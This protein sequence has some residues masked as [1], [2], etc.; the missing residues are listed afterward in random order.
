[1]TKA[2]DFIPSDDEH[3]KKPM[4]VIAS[5]KAGN[6]VA[7]PLAKSHI[8]KLED[9]TGVLYNYTGQV[10]SSRGELVRKLRLSS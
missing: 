4:L 9:V 1:M 10:D 7:I 6:V 3:H 2:W 5:L 8:G